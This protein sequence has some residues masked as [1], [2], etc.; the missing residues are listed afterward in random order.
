MLD[1]LISKLKFWERDSKDPLLKLLFEKYE[2]NML[3]IPR[4]KVNLGDI[5]RLSK[6]DLKLYPSTN[7]RNFMTQ[8]FEMPPVDPPETLIDISGQLS[9][10]VEA[11]L[12]LDLLQ[13]FLNVLSGAGLGTRIKAKYEHSG[14]HSVR[15]QFIGATREHIDPFLFGDELKNKNIKVKNP[16]FDQSDRYFV[17]MG[18]IRSK[19]ISI[20]AMNEKNQKLDVGIDI[21]GIA[22]VSGGVNATKSEEGMMTYKNTTKELGIGIE[23]VELLYNS[24]GNQFKLEEV[25][26]VFKTRKGTNEI[27]YEGSSIIRS[28][29]GDPAK[30]FIFIEIA[31]LNIIGKNSY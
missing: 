3:S 15:F 4:E 31:D 11:K 22:D 9:G 18:V 28:H 17:T 7:I 25:N 16:A 24:E 23:L 5:Y 26:K 13:N 19:S 2:F 14:T 8:Q 1:N 12:G 21:A 30:G 20:L 6:N 27:T 29:I 10:D